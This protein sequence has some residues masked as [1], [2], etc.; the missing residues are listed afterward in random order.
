MCDLK[1]LRNLQLYRSIGINFEL[2]EIKNRGESCPIIQHLKFK[3]TYTV[4]DLHPA[5]FAK[6]YV[7]L[8]K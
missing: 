8:I 2:S 3:L 5:L 1:I 6:L 7:E 4:C